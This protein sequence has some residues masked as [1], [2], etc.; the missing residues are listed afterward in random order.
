MDSP[1]VV[2]PARVARL[3]GDVTG[4]RPVYRALA[5]ALRQAVA[6]GRVPVGARLPGERELAAALSL[7]R[8]TVSGAYDVLRA[9]GYLES[10]RGSGTRARLP[11]GTQHRPGAP[12]FHPSVPDGTLDLTCAA[13]RAPAEVLG[14][15][16]RAVERLP[17]YLT[18]T[19]YLTVGLPEL[20]ELLAQR[21]TDRG[22]PTTADQIVVTS[23]SLA[24]IA[25]AVRVLVR[26]GGRVA[27]EDPGYP[28]TIALL[29][30]A[31]ARLSTLA[32]D[33][34][35]GWDLAEASATLRRAPTS[36]AFLLPDF[37]NPTGALLDD[38]GRAR[39]AEALAVHGT[40]PV[41]DETVAEIHLEEGAEVPL[42]FAAYAPGTVTVGGASKSH[43]G[44]LRVGWLR[45]PPGVTDR[46]VRAKVLGD[47]G[48]PVVEQLMLA[49]LL[50]ESPG[51]AADHLAA[52]RESR[53]ALLAALRTRLPEL[54]VEVPRGGLVLW[55]RLPE[56]LSATALVDAAADRGLLLAAG[57]RFAVH[58]GHDGWVRIPYVLPPA[59]MEEAVARLA[60]TAADLRERG[61]HGGG[62]R[63]PPAHGPAAERPIVA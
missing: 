59:Q 57:P 3:V 33:P 20:R 30:E 23:G 63:R 18:G 46:Y 60:L 14:A 36:A 55:C 22:A 29:R 49:E 40:T 53:D 58:G 52:L 8:T 27:V 35:S 54:R 12:L 51:P 7:S 47:L 56:G 11:Y 28:N 6:D 9:S 32:V 16:E 43:W 39:L 1:Q 13:T 31:G 17:G 37:H 42:P 19:G 38:P 62:R 26:R 2:G 50:R 24:G 45:L 25:A 10:R 4:R 41:V 48:V 15:Y 21:Y 61:S 5:D 44:G 34:T